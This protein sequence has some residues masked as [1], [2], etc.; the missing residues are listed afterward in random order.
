MNRL[1]RRKS[2]GG[3][4]LIELI[5]VVSVLSIL[6]AVISP[7]VTKLVEKAKISRLENELAALKTGISSVYADLGVYPSDVGTSQ[8]PG[9]MTDGRVPYTY[10]DEWSGPYLDHWPTTHPWGGTYDY[11]YWG[12]SD[13][14]YDGT[15][16]N[17]VFLTVRNYFTADILNRIDGDLDDGNR[18]TGV[19][20]HDGYSYLRMFVGEGGRW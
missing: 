14:N 3:F 16:G 2:E 18:Y 10:R 19:I 11:E 5:I 9:L 15:W 1:K 17:E 6:A 8:D 12:N 20:R 7:Q 4:S 13:F